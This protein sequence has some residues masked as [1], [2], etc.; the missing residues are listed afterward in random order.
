MPL[1]FFIFLYVPRPKLEGLTPTYD[2]NLPQPHLT[3]T[4]IRW[5]NDMN[6]KNKKLEVF[7]HL[8]LFGFLFLNRKIEFCSNFPFLLRRTYN[9]ITSFIRFCSSLIHV[10]F[11]HAVF[12]CIR[13]IYIASRSQFVH[14]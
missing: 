2:F 4:I 3:V 6:H 14:M 5:A 12:F 1:K 13:S 9:E 7:I 11:I 8:F 10:Q